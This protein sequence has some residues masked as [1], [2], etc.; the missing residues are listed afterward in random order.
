[1]KLMKIEFT[2]WRDPPAPAARRAISEVEAATKRVA[3]IVQR[4]AG[5]RAELAE[6]KGLL[7]LG[8]TQSM[9]DRRAALLEQLEAALKAKAAA[10]AAVEAAADLE[11]QAIRAHAR[12]GSAG[13]QV[14]NEEGTAVVQVVD[15]DGND[16]PEGAVY[17]Y[18]ITDQAPSRPAWATA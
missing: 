2:E 13:Y 8:Q 7:E 17:G 1:M 9:L 15:A 3:E 18:R 12:V 5:L 6:V 14:L 10:R 11:T 4:E 16:L